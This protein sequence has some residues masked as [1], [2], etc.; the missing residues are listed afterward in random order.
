MFLRGKK[1]QLRQGGVGPYWTVAPPKKKKKKMKKKKK[2]EEEDDEEEEEKKKKKKK[3][4]VYLYITVS[5]W[6]MIS[7][8]SEQFCSVNCR[9]LEGLL[10][11]STV[12]T[13]KKKKK[14]QN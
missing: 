6:S 2:K 4:Y 12:Q 13:Q 14:H 1:I 9:I 8:N 5:S 10:P 3:T 7:V 11:Y